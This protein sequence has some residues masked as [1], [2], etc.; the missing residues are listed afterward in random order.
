MS[1]TNYVLI[2]GQLVEVSDEVLMHW[3][4]IKREKKNGRW[5]YYYDEG[6]ADRDDYKN[7]KDYQ[8]AEAKTWERERELNTAKKRLKETGTTVDAK[9][10][11]GDQISAHNNY[12]RAV[13]NLKRA[14]KSQNRAYRK[15]QARTVSNFA[16][17]T[18]SKGA[19]KVANL[20]SKLFTK[21]K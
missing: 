20:F 13:D 1:K 11:Y 5:V 2:H 6:A 15:Y 16:A 8:K 7:A 14:S 19:V 3:K 21:K 18:I 17:K 9:I 4:Y 12:K 10:R